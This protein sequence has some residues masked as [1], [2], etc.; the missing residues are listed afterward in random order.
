MTLFKNH[1]SFFIQTVEENLSK[2]PYEDLRP[3]FNFQE[4]G[5]HKQVVVPIQY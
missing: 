5:T 4:I 3:R 2:L 1:I